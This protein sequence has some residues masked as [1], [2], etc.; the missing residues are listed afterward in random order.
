MDVDDDNE[1]KDDNDL[2][3]NGDD[4]EED[5]D[6]DVADLLGSDEEPHEVEEEEEPSQLRYDKKVDSKSPSMNTNSGHMQ[7]R[8]IGRKGH[9]RAGEKRRVKCGDSVVKKIKGTGPSNIR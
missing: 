9:E 3:E 1:E 8:T 2:I 5:D 6:D 7:E 4:E